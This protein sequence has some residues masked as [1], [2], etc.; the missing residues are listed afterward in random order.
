M[1]RKTVSIRIFPDGT[2]RAETHGVKGADCLAYIP[3]LEA[4]IQAETIDSAFTD[5]YHETEP[6]QAFTFRQTAETEH[7]RE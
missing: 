2:V 5:E 1:P 6:T 7:E 4:L 3:K